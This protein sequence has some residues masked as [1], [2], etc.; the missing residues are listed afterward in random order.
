[1]GALRQRQAASRL[2]R[3]ATTQRQRDAEPAWHRRQR[4]Q[5]AS[6]RVLLRVAAAAG[7]LQNHHSAQRV[8]P[9]AALMPGGQRRG[10]NAD[11]E[12]AVA[13]RVLELER[14]VRALAA[15]GTPGPGAAA[16]GTAG[17]GGQGPRRGT[18]RGDTRGMRGGTGG[19]GGTAAAQARGGGGAGAGRPGDWAC[20]SCAFFPCF[21][22]SQRCFRCKEPRHG[23]RGGGGGS[24][25]GAAR[26]S[27]TS[28]RF[29]GHR[30]DGAYLGPI[31]AG[32][33]RPL[34]GRRAP[35]PTAAGEGCPSN[36]VPG[37][38]LAAKAEEERRRAHA[39]AATGVTAAAADTEGFQPVRHGAAGGR[40]YAAAAE[41]DAEGNGRFSPTPIRNS[42]AALTEEE[43]GMEVADEDDGGDEGHHERARDEADGDDHGRCDEDVGRG[44]R[45]ADQGDGDE[46]GGRAADG[47]AGRE[48]ANA[49]QLK[50]E[51][52]AL[53]SA[54]RALEQ[55]RAPQSLVAAARAQR[56]E[57][58][59]R[60]RAA[61]APHPLSKRIRW[62]EAELRDAMSRERQH[63]V[64]L[65]RHLEEADK[66]TKELR[67]RLDVDVARTARKKAL[68]AS[69]HAEGAR[70]PDLRPQWTADKAATV[71]A[72]GIAMDVTPVL[73]GVIARLGSPL[74]QDAGALRSELEQCVI[75]IGRVEEVLREAAPM[76]GMA[77]GAGGP[78][79]YDIGKDDETETTYGG[80]GGSSDGCKGGGGGGC[81]WSPPP[82]AAAVPR[83]TRDAPNQPWKKRVVGLA[84]TSAT[85]S[86]SPSMEAVEEARRMLLARAS[87][88]T[89]P[90]PPVA[91]QAADGGGSD[92]GPE[93]TGKGTVSAPPLAAADTN[94][95]AEAERRQQLAAQHQ[96]L[97]VQRRQLEQADE[98]QRQL[99]EAQRQSRDE[100]RREELER[101]QQAMQ[102]A[103]EARAEQEARERAELVAKLSPQDRARAEAAHA[104][105]AAVGL[106]AFGS[107]QASEIAGLVHQRAV[108]E[109]ARGAAEA[110]EDVE[111]DRLMAMSPEEFG[112]WGQD[113]Q[114]AGW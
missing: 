43:D 96:V 46:E 30:D 87:G 100:R 24:G 75:S 10:G 50:G 4:R 18:D 110:G 49:A 55:Q 79:R 58:E 94:D 77:T 84:G 106:H 34:L 70:Q 61:K 22:R 109:A 52:Q 62:A 95:L 105:L 1:M 14:T 69:L 15:S 27:A 90:P 41:R 103:A 80:A 32:G 56:D 6:A 88:D 17:G 48:E 71:A 16:G 38:S 107:Q 37:A 68:I 108:H 104:E 2:A 28:G 81:R 26:S 45:D 111:I 78:A 29:S 36:R 98:H 42:W 93:A 86:I 44:P 63:R 74:G 40:T 53:C 113:R 25:G 101:H 47:G 7:T 91:G 33:S 13:A 9:P 35:P 97:E 82:A 114:A 11:G 5:R 19:G 83:W 112:R 64:E 60:W 76:A 85:S 54:A 12:S 20:P 21:A 99:E 57:A 73:A 8:R 72:T 39:T 59:A 66:R 89:S 51:W 23:G 102:Q 92:S 3:A 65:Q 67:E 31:G